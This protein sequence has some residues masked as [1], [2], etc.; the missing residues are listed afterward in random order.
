MVFTA[1]HLPDF[2]NC[3]AQDLSSRAKGAGRFHDKGVEFILVLL[4]VL[5]FCS[6]PSFDVFRSVTEIP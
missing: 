5:I 6:L 3:D 2:A 1:F 4:Q